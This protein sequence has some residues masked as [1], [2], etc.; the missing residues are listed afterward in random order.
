MSGEATK[1]RIV[2]A[3]IET[4]KHEGIVGT[5]AR[6]I[7]RRGDFNQ[8]LI[9]YHFGSVDE[10]LFA[11]IQET[12]RHRIERYRER[13]TGVKSFPDLVAIAADLHRED[14]EE[15]NLTIL[16]QLMAGAAG[17]PELGPRLREAFDPWIQVVIDAL[18][19]VLGGSAYERLVPLDD[20]GYAVSALFLGVELLAHLDPDRAGSETLFGSMGTLAE[21][22]QVML[23]T[24][25]V[26]EPVDATVQRIAVE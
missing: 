12:S 10:A 14:M 4:I 21:I 13:L 17:N 1:Q 2:D 5:S 9:F 6:A 22:V 20:L 7:A 3:T 8:A 26:P 16:T 25:E 18:R 24:G 15:G 11:A 19:D 23:A